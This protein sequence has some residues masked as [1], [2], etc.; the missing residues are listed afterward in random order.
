MARPK[1]IGTAGETATVRYLRLNGFGSAERRALAGQYDLGD[2]TGTPGICWEIKAGQAAKGASDGQVVRWL[3]ET[4]TERLNAHATYGVLVMV[5]AGIGTANAGQWWAV[6]PLWQLAELVSDVSY[7]PI[8]ADNNRPV[9][10]HLGTVVDL[11]RNKGY[12]DLTGNGFAGGLPP[13]TDEEA[14]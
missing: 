3:A 14:A 10:M 7:L 11:L 8:G 1:D 9:R 2:V 4:E 6:V 12:G 13:E 5:R